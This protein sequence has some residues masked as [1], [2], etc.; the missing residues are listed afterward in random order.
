MLTD[1]GRKNKVILHRLLYENFVDTLSDKHYVKFSCEKNG[2]LKNCCNINHMTKHEY[3][4][5]YDSSDSN[6]YH[7]T[8]VI[9]KKNK[10]LDK[11]LCTLR[12]D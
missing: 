12:F 4:V 7:N 5:N 8:D 9:V 6:C 2:S 11:D 3:L 1:R 10:N